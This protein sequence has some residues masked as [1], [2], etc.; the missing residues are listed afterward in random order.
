MK[1]AWVVLQGKLK[2]GFQVHSNKEFMLRLNAALEVG[3]A[4]T[5]LWLFTYGYGNMVSKYE[6]SNEQ[7]PFGVLISHIVNQIPTISCITRI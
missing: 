1:T 6:D 7:F 3:A 2:I 4:L 5:L